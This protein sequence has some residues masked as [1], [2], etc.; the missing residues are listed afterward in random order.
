MT[1]EAGAGELRHAG[2]IARRSDGPWRGVLIEG[3][4]GSGK[5]D[6]ALRALACGFS[7]V[8]DD[9]VLLWRS[10][11]RLFGRAPET[12]VGLIEVRGLDVLR[13]TPVPL[14]EVA[15]VVSAGEAER[16]PAPAWRD[17]LGLRVPAIVLP[18]SE[19][20]APAKLSRAL[21]HFDGRG[22]RRI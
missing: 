1:A 7:L 12:I 3:A 13:V 10:G 20:S 17:I 5:S 11:E 22:N 9:R 6:L 18:L 2:L 16:I 21:S 14:A 15:L 19:P 8:A 4:A